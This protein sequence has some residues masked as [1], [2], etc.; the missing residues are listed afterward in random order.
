LAAEARLL[1]MPVS[2]ELPTST[3]AGGIEDHL[4]MAP[5]GARRLAETAVLAARLAGLELV[6]SAQAIDLRG[7]APL[8]AG[9]GPVHARLR[10]MVPFVGAGEAWDHDLSAVAEWMREGARVGL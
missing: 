6:V 1:A 3:V 5:L 7:A 10:E 8:G 2:L 4:T 9:T